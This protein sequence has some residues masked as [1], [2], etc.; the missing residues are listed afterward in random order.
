MTKSLQSRIDIVLVSGIFVSSTFILAGS[1]F[2]MLRER[3][4]RHEFLAMKTGAELIQEWSLEKQ[5]FT[6]A[7]A[8]SALN[9][10]SN[11][12]VAVW[13]TDGRGT[14]IMPDIAPA[15]EILS[16]D[17]LRLANYHSA[18]PE[19]PSHFR[20]EGITYFTCSMTLP[21]DM[22]ILGNNNDWTV[23][24]IEDTARTPL[25]STS[26]ALVLFGFI[27]GLAAIFGLVLRRALAFALRPLQR[28]ESALDHLS[29]QGKE[30]EKFNPLDIQRYPIELQ[31]IASKFNLMSERIGQQSKDIKFF[32]S[33][34]SHEMRNQL[35][36]IKGYSY[37]FSK[38]LKR[39]ES[40]ERLENTS[41]KI[42]SVVD[43]S[44]QTLSNLVQLARSG[45]GSLSLD[46]KPVPAQPFLEQIASMNSSE[47]SMHVRLVN[48]ANECILTDAQ[49]L[50]SAIL[51]LIENAEKYACTGESVEIYG[52]AN[53][54]RK[55]FMIDV[56]DFGD[57]IPDDSIEV[58]FDRF[59][60]GSNSSG[61][62]GSGLGL[63]VVKE[64]LAAV[65]SEI[66]AISNP[67]GKGA[68]FRI[69]IPISQSK[70]C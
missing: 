7:E 34:V 25:S 47:K 18:E 1:E 41:S 50:R 54:D 67:Y 64:T 22:K 36:T 20:K 52:H 27:S 51:S 14:V 33:A 42:E 16:S 68:C 37:R 15:A 66:H 63:A 3:S 24:F 21:R 38:L 43:D 8:V 11:V 10:L 44:L 40:Q 53:Q 12:R 56:R 2:L 45:S 28:I 70:D 30:V 9:R 62:Y 19:G 69:V 31:N 65:N 29:L 49:V 23:R 13:I 60:R 61:K 58:I 57:G 26:S 32:T 6:P 59:K 48:C 55:Y 46:I 39:Q 35:T 4:R 17:L 5:S